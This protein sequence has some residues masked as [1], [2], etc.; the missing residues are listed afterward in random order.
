MREVLDR[1]AFNLLLGP[2]EDLGDESLLRGDGPFLLMAGNV[3][4]MCP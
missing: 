4:G 2:L 1:V 3:P